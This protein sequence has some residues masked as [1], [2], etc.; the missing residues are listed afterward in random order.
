MDLT[1]LSLSIKVF[2]R[3]L[4]LSLSLSVCLSVSLSLSTDSQ[5]GQ[6]DLTLLSLSV[7]VF[8]RVLCLSVC[9]Q[10]HYI[11]GLFSNIIVVLRCPCAVARAIKSKN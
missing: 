3:V 9:L 7:N 6:M 1:L 2:R 11:L 10:K 5:I 8:R 4:C